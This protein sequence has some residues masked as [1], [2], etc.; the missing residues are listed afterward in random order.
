MI[1]IEVNISCSKCGKVIQLFTE[2][3]SHSELPKVLDEQTIKA[4]M[5][6]GWILRDDELLCEDCQ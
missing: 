6:K 5:P 1:E 2:E 4:N 3:Y